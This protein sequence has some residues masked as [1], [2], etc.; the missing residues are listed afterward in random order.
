MY[1]SWMLNAAGGNDSIT[2]F[3]DIL[4]V[5][6]PSLSE[7]NSKYTRLVV[8]IIGIHDDNKSHPTVHCDAKLFIDGNI[9]IL[10]SSYVIPIDDQLSYKD[11]IKTKSKEYESLVIQWLDKFDV[12]LDCQHKLFIDWTNNCVVCCDGIVA[13]N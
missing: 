9:E 4:L 10:S 11:D 7:S 13:K 8:N 5:H 3:Y 1:F 2:Q 12:V 6:K